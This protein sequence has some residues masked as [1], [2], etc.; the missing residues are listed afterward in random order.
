M[1][2]SFCVIAVAT[3]ASALSSPVFAGSYQLVG[4]RSYQTVATSCPTHTTGPASPNGMSLNPET[5]R[6]EDPTPP[7]GQTQSL[8]TKHSTV[9][10]KW[11]PSDDFDNAPPADFKVSN[12]YSVTVS[13]SAVRNN[14]R[15]TGNANTASDPTIPSKTY[16]ASAGSSYVDS[17]T[18]PI[19]WTASNTD[20]DYGFTPGRSD[21]FTV[22]A[23]IGAKS[24][25]YAE[26]YPGTG[27]Q[28]T[29]SS[30]AKI[31]TTELKLIPRP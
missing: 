9:D 19:S 18:P 11:M 4:A 15:A 25:V 8:T 27:G 17:D 7:S 1:K 13:A 24:S 16:S 3:T 30:S 14:P 12:S 6:K 21:Q 10:F 28:I 5:Y 2:K 22:D 29:V 23:L 26:A 31:E 20:V